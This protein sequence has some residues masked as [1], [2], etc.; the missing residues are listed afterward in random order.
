MSGKTGTNERCFAEM[1]SAVDVSTGDNQRRDGS[2]VC[3][4]GG[5]VEGSMALVVENGINLKRRRGSTR[6]SIRRQLA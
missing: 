5:E 4:T 3:K 1:V 6:A 2:E